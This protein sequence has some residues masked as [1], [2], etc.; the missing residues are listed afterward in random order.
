MTD[1]RGKERTKTVYM[2]GGLHWALKV[3]CAA[4][5]TTMVDVLS[6]AAEAWSANGHAVP[7]A[8]PALE[9]GRKREANCYL[10]AQAHQ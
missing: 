3:A 4:E 9:S 5:R 7:E 10:R 8:L 6:D 2:H 1:T